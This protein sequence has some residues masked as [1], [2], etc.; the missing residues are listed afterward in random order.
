MT[1][2]QITA[3]FG[4]RGAVKATIRTDFPDRF[5]QLEEVYIA[6]PGAANIVNWERKQ[7][8][9]AKLQNDK[10]V[11]LRFEGLTK[12]EQVESLR[13]YNVAVPYSETVPLPEGEYYIFQI[14]GLDVYSTEDVYIGKVVNVERMPANDVYSVRGPLSKND[15]LIPAVKDIVK[16]IDLDTGR[17]TI[18]L[19]EGLV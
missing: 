3:P 5:E 19:L 6:P 4:L 14:I 15:V 2:A 9:S 12:V 17:M 8:L 13:G 18:E 7:L 11:V 1:I 16:N 10:V